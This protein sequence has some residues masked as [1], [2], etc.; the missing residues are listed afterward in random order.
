MSRANYGDGWRSTVKA[1]DVEMDREGEWW[2]VS[3]PELDGI[4]Q[5]RSAKE[6]HD[7]AKDYIAITLDVP[8]DSFDVHVRADP[9]QDGV[10]H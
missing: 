4:T 10:S 8:A 1:Y 2:M 3:I 7:M 9:I 6:A 5:A